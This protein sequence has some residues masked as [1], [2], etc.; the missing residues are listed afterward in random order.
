MYCACNTTYLDYAIR[1]A[2]SVDSFS[3]GCTVAI[4]VVN[5][6][7]ESLTRLSRLKARLTKTTLLV[8]H[9]D[10]DLSRFTSEG[11][12]AYYACARF[13][14]LPTLLESWDGSIL[15]LDAD[16]VI[17][18]R[19]AAP[20]TD[21]PDAQIALLRR[22][23]ADEDVPEDLAVAAGTVWI[24]NEP[25]TKL[26]AKQLAEQLQSEFDEDRSTWFVDQR[27][28]SRMVKSKRYEGLIGSIDPK[29]IDWNF[30]ND[31]VIWQAKG[32]RKHYDLRFLLIS[33]LLS[34]DDWKVSRAL[35]M[36]RFLSDLKTE[37]GT[38]LLF[39]KAAKLLETATP[40]IVV[41][42]PR[43]DLPWKRPS[44]RNVP[45][46]SEDV[47]ELRLYWMRFVTMLSNELESRGLDVEIQVLPAWEIDRQLVDSLGANLV[48]VPHR[49]KIDFAEGTT[50]VMFYM[51]EYYRWMFV[52]DPDGWSASASIY[53][54]DA[55]QL[56]NKVRSQSYDLYRKRLYAGE[57]QS[58]FAQPT[59]LSTTLSRSRFSSLIRSL[60]TIF[61]LMPTAP[62]GNSKIFFPLQIR[63][64]QS[65]KYFCDHAFDDVLAAVIAWAR[66]KKIEVHLKAHPVNPKLMQEYYARFPESTYVKWRDKNIH[67]LIAESDAVFLVNSGVGFEAL[68]HGKPIVMFGKAEYDCVAIKA[69]I[70]N[71]DAAWSAC[72]SVDSKTL[73]EQYRV[74]FD[75]FVSDYAIDL[76]QPATTKNRMSAL[77]DKILSISTNHCQR[78][79]G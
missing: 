12:K 51:Q 35:P 15:L 73:T 71:I 69:D 63:H 79:A 26:F 47:L 78:N 10:T 43:L 11:R 76:S 60:R 20:F 27:I 45:I 61:K 16:A 25:T 38:G 57:L 58:K 34:D 1:L 48:L 62:K 68:L 22:D 49:C 31:S 44:E 70:Q 28:L 37:D 21:L 13:L 59:E 56:Q 40:K 50:P 3:P 41:L 19:I 5:P 74:F 72:Q 75:W 36:V 55:V 29:F 14:R 33:Q 42:L 17:V 66:S 54:V 65:I 67:D 2:V 32:K 18:D 46:V 53:P 8:S 52:V 24:R 7:K 9:E 39:A 4:H 30:S 6:K 77:A 23:M 64:D